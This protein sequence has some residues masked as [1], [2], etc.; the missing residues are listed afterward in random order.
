MTKVWEAKVLSADH[1]G[2]RNSSALNFL[3]GLGQNTVLALL[4][5]CLEVEMRFRVTPSLR[6]CAVRSN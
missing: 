5:S 2:G 3:D 4:S 6:L 1:A